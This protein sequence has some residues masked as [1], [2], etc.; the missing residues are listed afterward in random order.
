M[1]NIQETK[2][3]LKKGG[4][5]AFTD[6]RSSRVHAHTHTLYP[7]LF[8]FISYFKSPAEIRNKKCLVTA[9]GTRLY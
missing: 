7:R 5:D 4:E 8:Y 2:V 3:S 9:G 1:R 6:V